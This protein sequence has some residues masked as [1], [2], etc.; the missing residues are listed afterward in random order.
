MRKLLF[1]ICWLMVYLAEAQVQVT[2]F[3]NQVLNIPDRATLI[4]TI[5]DKVLFTISADESKI[6]TLWVSDGTAQNT[7]KL[8]DIFGESPY[9]FIDKL[10]KYGYVYLKGDYFWR[11]DGN[12]L[13]RL[14]PNTGTPERM[15][16]L[17]GQ[18]LLCVS[19]FEELNHAST[20]LTAFAWM[21]ST[22]RTTVWEND[23]I[24]Y[25][26]IDSTLHYIKLNKRSGLYELGKLGKNGQLSRTILVQKLEE[27]FYRFDYISKNGTE[28]YFIDTPKGK[29]MISKPVNSTE[30]V[31][32]TD[33]GGGTFFPP[34]VKDTADNIY[35]L[36]HYGSVSVSQLTEDNQLVEKWVIPVEAIS[37]IYEGINPYV[38]YTYGNWIIC[39]D[40]LLFKTILGAEGVSKYYFNKID[41]TKGIT[42]RSRNLGEYFQNYSYNLSV[43]P[44]DDET[45]MLDNMANQKI[46]YSFHKDS[47]LKVIN[48][49][50]RNN[51][52]DTL[53]AISGRQIHIAGNIYS[54]SG[55][56]KTP[57]LPEKQA[58]DKE[59]PVFFT[60]TQLGN[61][62][63]FVTY[64]PKCGCYEAWASRGESNN[65]RLLL[66][67]EGQFQHL[68]D[69]S[70]NTTGYFQG[71]L[72]ILTRN[73]Q[74]NR[75]NIYETDGNLNGSRLVYTYNNGGLDLIKYN[76]KQLV[77][78]QISNY[79]QLLIFQ[80]GKEWYLTDIPVTRSGHDIFVT[81]D[82]T[83]VLTKSIATFRDTYVPYNELFR[84]TKDSLKMVDKAIEQ[85]MIEGKRLYYLRRIS[86]EV[87]NPFTLHYTDT[88]T[89]IADIVND[90]IHKFEIYG[91]KL[92]YQRRVSEK[93]F[94]CTVVDL[95]TGKTEYTLKNIAPAAIIYHN[96]VLIINNG[97]RLHLLKNGQ[98]REYNAGFSINQMQAFHE[99]LIL[100]DDRN[101]TF[102]DLA[103]FQASF[104]LAGMTHASPLFS[105]GGTY[106]IFSANKADEV[107]KWYYWTLAD[108]RLL[109]FQEAGFFI[110][111]SPSM[112]LSYNGYSPGT[113]IW[114]FNGSKF[115]R[116]YSIPYDYF[117]KKQQA[118]YN[119]YIPYYTAEK[120]PELGR[121]GMDSIITY[122]EVV[123]GPEG[124]KLQKAFE[125][126]GR[127]F[128]YAFT[129]THGWQIWRMDNEPTLVLGNE[130]EADIL[131]AYPNP[132]Q[133]WLYIKTEKTLPYKLINTRGQI[134]MQ[135]NLGP[136]QRINLQ[137]IPTGVYLIQLFDED[138]VFVR[139]IVKE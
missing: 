74:T 107:Y 28:Y 108:K 8:K 98:Y 131:T 36:Q 41:L 73:Y 66:S 121:I 93:S 48:Y 136:E 63:V 99:G 39:K 4:D 109:A 112:A 61:Q 68:I 20:K 44:L 70:K 67:L 132:S 134:V 82:E 55:A 110:A 17:N 2:D 60:Q 87:D 54:V 120:G 64:N 7:R 26:I 22:S 105:D 135:G 13:E 97:S 80:E 52:K 27:Y 53:F 29:K 5:Q 18:I 128:I 102:Y 81:A 21:D 43:K 10:K 103:K 116:K 138:R 101:L 111:L 83:Y 127:V 123:K 84:V 12:T 76:E 71:K 88:T 92:V 113:Y 77:F 115:T 96:G 14:T 3:D 46:T 95:P 137:Q 89:R 125:F 85:P 79:D 122:P 51:L 104:I 75:T 15:L 119:Y 106:L 58:F 126:M 30:Y 100:E 50:L 56:A 86:Q 57:L 59:V 45:Y 6:S 38:L 34:F 19:H 9:F 130:P 139:K 35:F 16:E 65:T 133:D 69:V 62:F 31:T 91:P 24:T 78:G 32:Y 37:K 1:S 25:Q 129:D 40:K 117:N 49:P 118:G 94:D 11:T 42:R 47:V 33:W 90:G 114:G 23:V 124:I 72:Y